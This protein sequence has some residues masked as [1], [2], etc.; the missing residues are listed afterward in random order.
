M[1]QLAIW[2][3]PALVS[4]CKAEFAGGNF[5]LLYLR[6]A[7]VEQLGIQDPVKEWLASY[8]MTSNAIN[9]YMILVELAYKGTILEGMYSLFITDP[10]ADNDTKVTKLMAK[11]HG[12][13]PHVTPLDVSL[14]LLSVT[15][16]RRPDRKYIPLVSRKELDY[17]FDELY[18]FFSLPRQDAELPGLM[19]THGFFMCPIVW[20]DENAE[21]FRSFGS[22]QITCEANDQSLEPN[23][24]LHAWN[25]HA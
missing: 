16:F 4:F 14:I 8:Q 15:L 17:D 20:T 7:Q 19:L 21:Y 22:I 12:R 24:I 23:E 25:C 9:D 18:A 10:D 3:W 2:R 13:L 6:R 1:G 5:R 11:C